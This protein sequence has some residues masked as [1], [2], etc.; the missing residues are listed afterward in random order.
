MKRT[1]GTGSLFKR[2]GSRIWWMQFSDE[3]VVYR[4]ST[5]EENKRRAELVLQRR[6]Q[7]QRAGIEPDKGVTV[8]A[9]VEATLRD[10]RINGRR[11]LEDAEARWRLHLEPA[12]GTWAARRVNRDALEK[13]IDQRREEGAKN[14]TINRELALLKRA[15]SLA[16]RHTRSIFT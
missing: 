5:G 2:A 1:Y 13:Y 12:F 9:L 6:V 16:G 4:E 15:F 11:S 8:R 3:G 7:E 10:Y 14:A